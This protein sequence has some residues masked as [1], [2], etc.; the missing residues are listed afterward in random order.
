M[1]QTVVREMYCPKCKDNFEEGSRRFCPTDGARL[2]SESAIPQSG[3]IFS[4]L[5]SKSELSHDLD[6]AFPD[7][8]QFDINEPEPL[9]EP[10]LVVEPE[11]VIF[12]EPE[13][14]IPAPEPIE[15]GDFFEFE[16]GEMDNILEPLVE[17]S[18]ILVERSDILESI[19]A[20]PEVLI[21]QADIL[22]PIETK[23]AARKVNP[24]DIP[25][26]HVEL[27][28]NEHQ[29]GASFLQADKPESFVGKTVKGRYR[30][31]EL[32]GGDDA[33]FA[34]L[35]LDK[36]V[37]DRKVL[38]RVLLHEDTDEMESNVID[39]ELVAL[40][41][42]SH[43]N[44]AR[45][46]DSGHFRDGK[47]FLVSEYIDAMSVNDILEQQGTFDAARAGRIIKQIAYALNE[48][49]QEGIVH[50]DLRPENIIITPGD[51][52]SEQAMLVNFGAS[53]GEPNDNNIGYK[54]PEV[55][56]GRVS[57]ISGDIYSL[58]VIAY[59]MLTG[60]LP[61]DST[62]SRAAVRSQYAGLEQLPTS[63]RPEL[64]LS[65]NEVFERALSF[66]SGERYVKARDFGDAFAAA[67]AEAK[68]VEQSP[69]KDMP[70]AEEPAWKNRS[71]EPPKVENARSNMIAG[72]GILGLVALL[73]FGWYYVVKHPIEPQVVTQVDQ[74]AVLSSNAAPAAPVAVS[75]EMP[76]L[77]RNIPQPPNTNYYQNSKQNLKGDLIRNFVGFTMYYPKDWKVNGAQESSVPNTRGKFIDIARLTPDGRPKEQMLVSY[78]PSKGTFKDDADKFPQLVKET[79][80]TLKKILPGYQMV[81]EGE[82]KVNGDWK[83]YE[84]KFQGSGMSDNGEKLTVWGRRLFIPAARPGVRNGFEITMLATSLA[85]DVK[86]VDEV[87][88]RG[89]LA[90]I[91]YSFEPS[92]NF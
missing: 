63:V 81:S 11:M 10:I 80:E 86:S 39:D 32:L 6:E 45:L 5:I 19:E 84:V 9:V 73:A 77:P 87:G 12:T 36:L 55:F 15:T 56:D 92:Q 43:P 72:A 41:H 75:T 23:P 33:S 16:D 85:D 25:A 20:G 58:A 4:N 49:H 78:Y 30:I 3:G 29:L 7:T 60:G 46:V 68:T 47:R 66:T 70:V 44:V 53:N 61:F 8:P 40:S 22:E 34:Y 82:I 62:S 24:L 35:A 69:A 21:K 51:T 14:A 37:D 88:V 89:E 27:E 31:T 91:L 17:R 1:I 52:D 79:N 48:V 2:I 18:P 38:V 54:A 90:S 76:P 83:A 50:R 57:T 26:G 65:V 28:K 42:I 67:M 59:E 13:A 74:G 64:P 71:P